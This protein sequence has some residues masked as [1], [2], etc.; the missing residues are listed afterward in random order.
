MF[1]FI[2]PFKSNIIKAGSLFTHPRLST[3]A[4]HSSKRKLQTWPFN[5]VVFRPIV[6]S[7]MP[8]FLVVGSSAVPLIRYF[9]KKNGTPTW[10]LI[11][12]MPC[13]AIVYV[14]S[15]VLCAAV[16]FRLFRILSETD[17]LPFSLYRCFLRYVL[18]SMHGHVIICSVDAGP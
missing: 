3:Y 11:R 7:A 6:S 13:K 5:I 16:H 14:Q 10:D 4:Y 2:S 18:F 1:Q 15:F 8:S 12:L 9:V 17:M